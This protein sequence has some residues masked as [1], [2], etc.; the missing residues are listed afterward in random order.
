MAK[1]TQRETKLLAY[2][3][4]RKTWACP[5][6]GL[7]NSGSLGACWVCRTP[8]GKRPKLLWSLYERACKKAGIEATGT[9]WTPNQKEPKSSAGDNNKRGVRRKAAS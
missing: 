5:S 4:T 7:W 6:C 2:P 9:R 3:P 1:L 8:S